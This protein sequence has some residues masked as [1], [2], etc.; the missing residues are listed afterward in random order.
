MKP[1]RTNLILLLLA[2]WPALARSDESPSFA[3]QVRPFF[4]R[5]CSECHNAKREEGGLNLESYK[6][7]QEGGANGPVLVAGK[8][9]DSKIVGQVEGKRKPTMPPKTARQPKAE[10]VAVLR[11]WVEAGA[12]DDTDTVVVNL[13]EIKPRVQLPPPV[14]A[15]AYRPDGKL[16]AAGVY[17]DVVF[18]DA[19]SGEVAGKL[20][21]AGG[22]VSAVAFSRKG[23]L[24]AMASGGAGFAGEIRLYRVSD[25]AAPAGEPFKRIEAHR[26]VIQDL[27]FSP[28]GTMLASCGYDRLIKLWDT[29]TG[30]EIRQL[31]D[32][33]DAVYS[34]SFSADGML[35]ASG[36]ADRAVKVWDV[37]S[38]KRLYTLGEST[39]WV[40]GVAWS[41][42]GHL[43]A[44][45]GVDKSIRV[46][47]AGTQ[48]G[49]VVH[50]VFAH[51]GPVT[52][53]AYSKDGKTLYSVGEDHS[54]KAWDTERM[55]ERTVYPKQPDAVLALAVRPDQ[56]Q[57]AVGRY[58]G[59]LVLLEES[60]GKVQSE[61]LPPK[62]KP[63]VL[64]K[65]TPDGGTRGQTVVLRLQGKNLDGATEVTTSIPG[66][67]VEEF[68]GSA[69]DFREARFA[70]PPAAAAGAYTIAVK[71]LAGTTAALPFFVDRFHP[72]TAAEGRQSPRTCPKIDLPATVVGS[73]EKAGAVDYI[74]F[75]ATPGQEI[76]VQVVTGT[77]APKLDAVLQILDTDGAVL[78][79][80]DGGLLGYK[81]PQ[82]ATLTLAVRDREYRGGKAMAYRIH[83]GDIPIVTGVFPLGVRRGMDAEVTVTGVNL[84]SK[85]TLTV[86]V[87]ADAAVGSRMPLAVDAPSG[88]PLGNTSVVAGEFPEVGTPAKDAVIPVPGTANGRIENPVV[89][90][91]YRFTAKKGT[92]LLLEVEARRLGSPLDSYIEI[93]DD[94]GQ[95]LPRA[96][97]RCL[98][99]TY[100]TFRDH[101]SAG[102]GIRIESWTEL[103]M[104]D[105]LLVG[106]E[107]MR[108]RE[109][110]KNP[111]DDCQFFTRNGRREGFLGTTPTHHPQGQPMYKVAIHP[112]G[113]TFPPNGL[114]VVTLYY[115]NDDGGGSFG[116]DSR[117]VF[118]PP[119]D[120]DYRVRIGDA[121]GQGGPQHAYR[122]TVRPPRPGFTVSINPT[123]PKVAK[124]A[125]ASMS[126]AVDRIDEFDG[127]IEL[128]LE[129][130]PPG[131]SAPDTTIPAGENATSFALAARADA[132][133]PANRPR[134][135]LIARAKVNGEEVVR[136]VAVS[137][138]QIIDAGDV[139]TTTGQDA[140]TIKPGAEAR[141]Q[142]KIERR[143]GFNG[144]VP[145]EVRGLPY[146]VR[147]L[148]IGLNGILITEKETTRT[149]VLYAEPWVEPTEHP[150][151]VLARS[152]RKGTEHAAK[153]VLLRVTAK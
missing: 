37:A 152:E 33:S 107:L 61:P 128:H 83:A 43:L 7:L 113:T 10:E 137:M 76:G 105:Y 49:K 101:D 8:A 134:I 74:R 98:A 125:A 23:N 84:G 4:A 130:L 117:L 26:D 148:D 48:G 89:T 142:V 1:G 88:P 82:A 91:E 38:G 6:T 14:A 36:A 52:R 34:V 81:A 106:D 96:T 46:W 21:G 118:D 44:A 56:K 87:P 65:V 115:R 149:I 22:R 16:L 99:K 32:H 13:P 50:S 28:D 11:A 54:V 55:A 67:K 25:G 109:L 69:P 144:R 18:V 60:S 62:P 146:G 129:N 5:Y 71:T 133:I 90:H 42:A 29:A 73:V 94:K 114:P 70:I 51:E 78:A 140:V 93:L 104:K 123:T 59:K 17:K 77:A 24:F 53:V 57:I 63:P 20:P 110:P 75:D 27:A 136:E 19:G 45:G 145:V 151:V 72:V 35:L 124:G 2:A 116:K 127:P 3:K 147:V 138:P 120:G 40:Y 47:E 100:T 68:L 9:N 95:P 31:K 92:R 58:D 41:P 153:S 66:V 15:L 79:E 39:D 141:L 132:E 86:K 150:F 121:R 30:E 97:L 143:E 102:G 126:V 103:A 111:D 131:F 64:N 139:V 80:S 85:Q 108:V 119:A 112:P 135:K 12:R 122:L